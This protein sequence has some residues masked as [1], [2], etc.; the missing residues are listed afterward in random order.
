MRYRGFLA[1]FVSAMLRRIMNYKNSYRILS[2]CDRMDGAVVDDRVRRE[3]RFSF[4]NGRDARR[5]TAFAERRKAVFLG[6]CPA[7]FC[8]NMK[9]K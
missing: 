8:Y 2:R 4:K 1:R 5:G 7:F 6:P 3:D 9:T